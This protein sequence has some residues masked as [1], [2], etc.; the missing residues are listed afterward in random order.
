MI[1]MCKSQ[2]WKSWSNHDERFAA[3][4]IICEENG[5]LVGGPA[6]SGVL[7]RMPVNLHGIRLWAQVPLKDFRP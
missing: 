5:M 3:C 4:N 7:R 6:S 2:S 1:A